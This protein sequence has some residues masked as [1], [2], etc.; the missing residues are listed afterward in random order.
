[1]ICL[2]VSES[3]RYAA[4]AVCRA[5]LRYGVRWVSGAGVRQRYMARRM[6]YASECY[7]VL[8]A[9]HARKM[10]EWRRVRKQAGAEDRRRA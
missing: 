1:M 10:P 8:A 6:R 9:V 7:G 5:Q 4:E 2:C 3:V